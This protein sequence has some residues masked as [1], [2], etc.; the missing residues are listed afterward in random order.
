MNVNKISSKNLFVLSFAIRFEFL[1]FS[2]FPLI[3]VDNHR[4]SHSKLH[5]LQNNKF[6]QEVLTMAKKINKVREGERK[7]EREKMYVQRVYGKGRL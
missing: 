1:M 2:R 6:S 7:K 5:V 3:R 4:R